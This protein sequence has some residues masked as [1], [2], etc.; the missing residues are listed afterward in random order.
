MLEILWHM[1][2]LW[3]FL[4]IPYNSNVQLLLKIK[5]KIELTK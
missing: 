5:K 3:M 1:L 2:K 4:N